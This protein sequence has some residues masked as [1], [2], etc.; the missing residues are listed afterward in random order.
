MPWRNLAFAMSDSVRTLL[1][2]LAPILVAGLSLFAAVASGVAGAQST[3]SRS[4]CAQ[5]AAACQDAGFTHGGG[6]PGTGVF[7]DCVGPLLQRKS[8]NALGKPLPR[9]DP[10]LVT[11]CRERRTISPAR[12]EPASSAAAAAPAPGGA[13]GP[14]VVFV[15]AN[16]LAW[17]LV[18]FMPNVQKMQQEGVTFTNHFVTDPSCCANRVSILTGQYP[19]DHGVV[20][21]TRT[22]GAYQTFTNP[23]NEAAT[24]AAALEAAGYRTALMGHYLHGY[25]PTR[26]P[27]PAG[28]TSWAAVGNAYRGFGYA[29]NQD[30]K[31]LRFGDRAEDYL[32]DVL[33]RLATRFV[34]DAGNAPFLLTVATLAPHAPYTPAPRDTA[35]LADVKAPRTPA[36]DAPPD[37]KAP[38]WLGTQT[39]LTPADVD[40]IDRD[41]RKRAQA[42]LAIDALVGELRDALAASG[43]AGNTY[44]FFSADSGFHMGEHRLRPGKMTPFDTDIRVPLIV[45]GPGVPAGRSVDEI[46][47]SVDLAPTFA[48]IAGAAAP[49]GVD[50]ASLLPFLRGASVAGWRSA[51]LIEHR[52]PVGD[53]THPDS[54]AAGSGNPI[55]YQALRAKAWLYVEY[56]DG[57]KVFHDLAKDP[58]ELANSYESLSA[59]SRRAL[60]DALGAARICHAAKSCQAAQTVPR[61]SLRH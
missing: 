7:R 26:H 10:E 20:G 5:L 50:G 53:V 49:S 61:V 25:L 8:V 4:P 22:A 45:T 35:K 16:D 31:I 41:F 32:T 34:R 51:A 42:A 3:P 2:S 57:D 58:H 38:S 39:A 18:P 33:G 47:A 14:N 9:I 28:W 40:A 24:F 29:L 23:R 19:H 12:R 60:R 44:F 30:G 56:A 27:P 48:D 37:D 11:A 55:T 43:A 46:V 15:L 13:R 6:E 59:A 52:G 36:F 21:S 54:P 17:N 1:L